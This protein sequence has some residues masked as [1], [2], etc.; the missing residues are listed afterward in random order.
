MATSEKAT[1]R[2]AATFPAL[3]NDELGELWAQTLRSYASRRTGSS[4][5]FWRQLLNDPD[6]GALLDEFRLRAI[7]RQAEYDAWMNALDLHGL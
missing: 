5:D 6:V 2:E 3:S 1:G 7:T 4:R